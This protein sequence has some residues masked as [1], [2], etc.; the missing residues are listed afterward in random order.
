MNDTQI[1]LVIGLSVVLYF[2]W[3]KYAALKAKAEIAKNVDDA[4]AG[5]NTDE[6]VKLVLFYTWDR[7]ASYSF[8]PKLFYNSLF[9]PKRRSRNKKHTKG[10]RLPDSEKRIMLLMF[11]LILVNAR[12]MPLT[13]LLIILFFFLRVI[14]FGSIGRM[15]NK[16]K[17][18]LSEY[19]H[20][21]NFN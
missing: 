17:A 10:R 7:C 13:Y 12:L 20:H 4:L 5:K 2:I 8:L 15:T 18:G 1:G 14:L 11:K 19:L 9:T 3:G 21:P 6:N 16:A